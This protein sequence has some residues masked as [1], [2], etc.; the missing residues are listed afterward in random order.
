M[1]R[2]EDLVKRLGHFRWFAS[3]A[4][5]TAPPIDRM[6]YRRTGHSGV[7]PR[8][9][10][11]ML[12]TT[13]GRKSGRP[14]TVPVLY[15]REGERLVVAGSNWGKKQDPAWALN[16]LANPVARVQVGKHV[17][18]YRARHATQEERDR[19]WPK[20]DEI[21]PAYRTYRKRSGRDIRVF[22]LEP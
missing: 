5:R 16:L 6:A 21:W 10:P 9:L 17:G 14:R 18:E 2:F 15:V 8:G 22:V 4:S 12:L 7:T 11:T 20:L 3:L 19:L 13:A 1:S